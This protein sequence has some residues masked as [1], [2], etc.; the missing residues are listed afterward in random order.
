MGFFRYPGGKSKLNKLILPKLIDGLMKSSDGVEYRE[1]FFGGGSVGLEILTQSQ[2]NT[3][4][5]KFKSFWINDI[6]NGIVCLWD[7]VINDS[8]KLK[9]LIR[10]FK[11]TVDNFYYI[12]EKLLSCDDLLDKTLIG[13]YKL[14]IHQISYSGLGTK[15]GGP[16]GG[17]KQKSKYGIDCR[18]SVD[19]LCKKI[20]FYNKFFSKVDIKCTCLDFSDLF[21]NNDTNYFTYLDPPYFIKG[22]ELYQHSFSDKDHE[23]LCSLLKESKNLWVLSYDCCDT[24][25]G[26]Y[27]GWAKIDTICSVNYSINTA[28]SKKELLISNF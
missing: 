5:N 2:H 12:K 26:Y 18:W 20:D 19:Y 4:I 27:D 10:S 17:K 1:P 25:M 14:V 28:R 13:F 24:I 9:D 23:R 6:D 16:L 8:D 7:A 15:S 21:I 22:S 11:P 3:F